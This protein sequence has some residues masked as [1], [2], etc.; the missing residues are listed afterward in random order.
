MWNRERVIVVVLG[1]VML[2]AVSSVF[3]YS[4]RQVLFGLPGVQQASAVPENPNGLN[5]PSIDEMCKANGATDANMQ[6]CQADESAAAEFVIS[7]MGLNNFINNG[8]IDLEQIQLEA[9]F[10]NASDPGLGLDPSLDPNAD[11][12]G[13]GEPN[14]DPATGEIVTETFDSAAEIALFC[15]SESNDWLKMHDCISRY[16]PMSRFDGLH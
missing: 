6:A 3:L 1:G 16:D 5:I 4:H 10:P 13:L 15:L 9:T 11:P 12:T 8:S 2:I 14:I 7:W